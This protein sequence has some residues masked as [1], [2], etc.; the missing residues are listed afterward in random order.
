MKNFN[1]LISNLKGGGSIKRVAVVAADDEHTLEAVIRAQKEGLVSPVL[2]GDKAAI[3]AALESIEAADAAV[4]IVET[5]SNEAS[6]QTAAALINE[7]KADFI[8]KG[9]LETSVLMKAVVKKENNLRTGRIMSHLAFLEIPTYHKL[10]ALSDVAMLTYPDLDQKK[11]MIENAVTALVK[12]GMKTPKVAVLSASE[13]V[14]PKLPESADAKALK[15]MNIEGTINDCVIEGPISYD[16]AM[17]PEA[18]AIKGYVSPVAGDADLLIM[19]NLTAG[20]IFMKGL[21]VSGGAKAAGIIVGAKVPIVLTS[22]ASSIDD[23]LMSLVIAA[24]AS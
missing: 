21:S 7:G 18:S 11:Q 4:D 5:E 23:K 15:D 6:A 3:E 24:T 8:M 22:R 19:P 9:N 20:N 2:I 17:D 16:L 12:M 1:E 14:N 13:D 10:V